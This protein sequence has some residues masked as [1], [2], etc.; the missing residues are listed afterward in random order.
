MVLDGA[1]WLVGWWFKIVFVWYAM[2]DTPFLLN[3]FYCLSFFFLRFW[4][5]G[6]VGRMEK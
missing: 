5:A 3:T 6:W 2:W 1:L 4:L